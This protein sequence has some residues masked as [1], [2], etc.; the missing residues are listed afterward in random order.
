M[1]APDVLRTQLAHA[2]GWGEAHTSLDDAV[3]RL[4]AALR[5]K[6]AARFPHSPWELLEH[7]RLGQ[8][9]LLDFCRNADYKALRWPD[10]YW[11]ATPAP[12]SARAW[13]SS[14]AGYR[15]DRADL[16][17]LVNDPTI[18]LAAR[19]PHG[20]GQTY[21]REVLI[22]LDHASYHVGQLVAVLRALGA[23]A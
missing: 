19:I 5:G 16:Q 10:D 18:D 14:I 23:W 9:D 22:A 13:A 21:A 20:T 6:R 3:K 8:H 4:P 11:P 1:S 2:L 7:I 17:A 15:R 12:P